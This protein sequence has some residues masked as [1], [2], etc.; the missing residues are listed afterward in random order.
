MACRQEGG[1][2][3]KSEESGHDSYAA[4][5]LTQGRCLDPWIGASKTVSS[6]LSTIDFSWK[7]VLFVRRLQR[8]WHLM[9]GGQ[10]LYQLV[11][12]QHPTRHPLMQVCC[13]GNAG[14]RTGPLVGMVA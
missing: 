10:F 1:S 4:D 2:A 5:F 11:L 8:D 6:Q 3:L 9:A 13:R 12:T 14:M 7:S